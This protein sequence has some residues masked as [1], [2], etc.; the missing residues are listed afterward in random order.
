MSDLNPD[1]FCRKPALSARTTVRV[2]AFTQQS[3]GNSRSVRE[4][5]GGVQGRCGDCVG[6]QVIAAGSTT[7]YRRRR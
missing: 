2:R 7:Y 1:N 4:G 5:F 6:V 3:A